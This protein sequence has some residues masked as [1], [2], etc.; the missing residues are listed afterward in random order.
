MYRPSNCHYDAA[1]RFNSVDIEHLH[2]V[3]TRHCSYISSS[4]KSVFSERQRAL[5]QIR[6]LHLDDFTPL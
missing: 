3:M 4:F 2:Y 1:K 6:I 5:L